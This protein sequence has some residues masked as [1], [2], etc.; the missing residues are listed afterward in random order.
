MH[1]RP[2]IH[3]YFMQDAVHLIFTDKMAFTSATLALSSGFV[4]ASEVHISLINSACLLPSKRGTANTCIRLPVENLAD[5]EP[6]T[7]M[8]ARRFISADPDADNWLL[9]FVYSIL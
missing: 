5:C 4:S 2:M 1:T 6:K 8:G 7:L 9:L 3:L